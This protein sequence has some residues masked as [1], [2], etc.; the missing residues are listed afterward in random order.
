MVNHKNISMLIRLNNVFMQPPSLFSLISGSLIGAAINILTSI[1]S[2]DVTKLNLIFTSFFLIL[3]SI[4][5]IRISIILESINKGGPDAFNAD[6]VR[7]Q[8]KLR[9]H[10]LTFTLIFIISIF[11]LIYSYIASNTEVQEVI[12]YLTHILN[13]S[14]KI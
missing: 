9:N 1:I 3:S 10:L 7:N 5:L 8:D 13:Y 12:E 14:A 6:L 11:A 4:P 2:S